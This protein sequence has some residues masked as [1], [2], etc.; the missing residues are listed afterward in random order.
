MSQNKSKTVKFNGVFGLNTIAVLDHL[1]ASSYAK[2]VRSY[3]HP[4]AL[5]VLYD[6]ANSF[7]K[8]AGLYSAGSDS[9]NN[10]VI[11]GLGGIQQCHSK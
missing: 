11:P 1:P 8:K 5:T 3:E 4:E 10:T 7:C 2:F 9:A 6:L